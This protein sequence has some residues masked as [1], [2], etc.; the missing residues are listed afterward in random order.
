M[1][2]ARFRW[3]GH[4]IEHTCFVAA[5]VPRG[6]A[7]SRSDAVRRLRPS[8]GHVVSAW[9]RSASKAANE[10]SPWRAAG[11]RRR[12]TRSQPPAVR[13]RRLEIGDEYEYGICDGGCA[14]DRRPAAEG[15]VDT[16]REQAQSV[17]EQ[18]RARAREQVDRQSS[19]LGTR[20][21][22]VAEDLRSVAEHLRSQGKT[23]PAGLVEQAAQ[24]VAGAG[25]YLQGTDGNRI[26]HDVEA[27][28]RRR[29]W[30][31]IAGGLAAGVAASRLLK[32]SSTDRYRS[33]GHGAVPVA[34]RVLRRPPA[35][36]APGDEVVEP[37]YR[38]ASPVGASAMGARAE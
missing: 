31:A 10:R 35:T 9:D 26:L 37:G 27:L 2:A 1:F 17:G 18:A 21:S 38:T 20:A 25:D 5:V 34:R 32:A 30:T 33:A 14:V 19:D 15:L 23:G 13:D 6:T 8:H 3:L 24:R 4:R 7:M 16:V 11:A 28:G 12:S 29:P 36:D 22:S